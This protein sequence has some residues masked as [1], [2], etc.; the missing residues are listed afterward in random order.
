[1]SRVPIDVGILL[2]YHNE[3]SNLQKDE[4]AESGIC[5]KQ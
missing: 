2:I 3:S 4:S 1:M 5:R